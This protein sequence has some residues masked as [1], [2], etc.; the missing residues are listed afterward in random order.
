MNQAVAEK[1]HYLSV[2]DRSEQGGAGP[3]WVRP[4]RHEAISRFAVLGFPTTKDEEWKY[5]SVSPILQFPFRPAPP[6]SEEGAAI[7]AVERATAIDLPPDRLVFVNGHYAPKLS[8]VRGVRERLKA[9]S[10]RDAFGAAPDSLK[11]HLARYADYRAHAFVALNTAFMVDGA[12]L[13]VPVTVVEAYFGAPDTVYFTN[14]V[15]EIVA[16][17]GAVVDHYKLVQESDAAFHVATQQARLERNANFVSHLILLGGGLVRNDVNA[18]LDGEGVECALNGLFLAADDQHVD[19]HTRIDHVKPHGCS[20][21]LYKGILNGKA[22]GVFSGKI[23]VHKSAPKTDAKQT[24]KNLLLSEQALIDTKPQLEIHNNDVK[25]THGSTIGQLDQDALF[26]LRAR[27]IGLEEARE[28]LTHAFASEIIRGI[29]VAAIR[30]QLDRTV[31][32]SLGNQFR[33]K[34]RGS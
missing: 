22:R 19:S 29:K 13:H 15:T 7:A 5:T 25:C 17:E 31:R 27:G 2:F 12:Y 18:V 9:L 8:S 20:R 21:E 23:Y 32:T 14:G 34:E 10:L 33:A 16:G 4:L 3:P 6:P 24:N 30:D 1:D 28:L 26:Y 11:P